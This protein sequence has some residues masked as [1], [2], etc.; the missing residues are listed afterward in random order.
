M[1]L[2]MDRKSHISSLKERSWFYEVKIQGFRYHMSNMNA[3]IGLAQKEPT[4]GDFGCF[5]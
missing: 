5:P 4:P 3:A 2:G 1:L